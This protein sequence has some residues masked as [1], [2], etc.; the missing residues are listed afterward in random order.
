MMR[1]FPFFFF[2][3]FLHPQQNG[4]RAVALLKV[5]AVAEAAPGSEIAPRIYDAS[6]DW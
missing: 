4:G 6:A 1:S 5:G 3:F 2:S